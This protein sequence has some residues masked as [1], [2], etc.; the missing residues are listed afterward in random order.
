MK[1]D[2]G[3]PPLYTPVCVCIVYVLHMSTYYIMR[4]ANK[5]VGERNTVRIRMMHSGR[6]ALN[7]FHS[8]KDLTCCALQFTR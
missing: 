7:P 2:R 3:D 1:L 6:N 4:T 5:R 8:V